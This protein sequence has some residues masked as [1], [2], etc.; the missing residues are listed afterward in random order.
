MAEVDRLLYEEGWAYLLGGP[1][2]AAV[3]GGQ[4]V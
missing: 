3:L 4:L 1:V 2:V